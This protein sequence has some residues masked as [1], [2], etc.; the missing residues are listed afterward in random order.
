MGRP[1]SRSKYAIDI[2][3][4]VWDSANSGWV[5]HQGRSIWGSSGAPSNIIKKL[6]EAGRNP[7]T[8]AVERVYVSLAVPK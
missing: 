7:E 1:V 4:R 3:F 2:M 8:L 5:V 6:V